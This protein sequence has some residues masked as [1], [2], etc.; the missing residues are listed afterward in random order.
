MK[1]LS[2]CSTSIHRNHTTTKTAIPNRKRSNSISHFAPSPYPQ[3]YAQPNLLKWCSRRTV[4]PPPSSP[5]MKPA[6]FIRY[7]HER[8]SSTNS[9][10]RN[11]RLPPSIPRRSSLQS[12]NG[13]WCSI[14]S[15]NHGTALIPTFSSNSSQQQQHNSMV[16]PHSILVVHAVAATAAASTPRPSNKVSTVYP[17][18]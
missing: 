11:H 1:I 15:S 7:Q 9:S 16:R 3:R 10:V 17:N 14:Y 18:V 5:L 8:E 4:R 2:I 6:E 13:S 12:D